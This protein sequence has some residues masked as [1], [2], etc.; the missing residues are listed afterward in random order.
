MSAFGY[1]NFQEPAGSQGWDTAQWVQWATGVNM[2]SPLDPGGEPVCS[3]CLGSVSLRQDGTPWPYCYPCNDYVRND[4]DGLA[5]ISYSH[6]QG[7][8]SALHRFKDF[9]PEWVW[10]GLPMCSILRE[11]LDR[12]EDCLEQRFGSIDLF[13]VVPAAPD[14][15]RGFDHMKALVQSTVG[16]EAAHNWD[17]DIL[18]RHPGQ[19]IPKQRPNYAAFALSA[20]RDLKGLTIGLIDD[21]FTSGATLTS[22]AAPL[23]SAGARVV[24]VTLGR[25]LN[26]AWTPSVPVIEHCRAQPFDIDRCVL[27]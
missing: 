21:T 23:R 13:T 26:A 19:A 16:W 20:P 7:L 24:G 12:H 15:E 3:L 27:E 14:V 25:Q 1:R 4:L 17:L 10:L 22:A 11:F 2:L 9:G 8:E 5:P 6:K 18:Q